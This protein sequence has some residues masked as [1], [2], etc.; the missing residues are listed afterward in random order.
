MVALVRRALAEVCTVPV[1]LVVHEI[2]NSLYTHIDGCI[3]ELGREDGG[4]ATRDQGECNQFVGRDFGRSH[5]SVGGRARA[6]VHVHVRRVRAARRTRRR[7]RLAVDGGVGRRAHQRAAAASRH[8]TV[9]PTAHVDARRQRV[10]RHTHQPRT[11]RSLMM[12]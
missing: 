7:R 9:V 10:L 1:L 5:L 8:G 3:A 6:L 12:S 4:V 2:G 11:R